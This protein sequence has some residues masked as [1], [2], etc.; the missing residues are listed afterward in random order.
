MREPRQY[1]AYDDER[2]PPGY[3]AF[4]NAIDNPR[5]F[6]FQEHERLYPAYVLVYRLNWGDEP[7][8][9][10]QAQRQFARGVIPDT[11][12]KWQWPSPTVGLSVFAAATR[13]PLRIQE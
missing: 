9:L 3:G 13:L 2:I 8:L 7:N 10:E 6:C 5:T 1:S 4:V 11:T 12:G